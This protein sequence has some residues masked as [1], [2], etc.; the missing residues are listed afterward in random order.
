L[1]PVLF[2]PIGFSLSNTNGLKLSEWPLLA[3]SRRSYYSLYT[4]YSVSLPLGRSFI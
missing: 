2:A 1:L 3:R 4:I